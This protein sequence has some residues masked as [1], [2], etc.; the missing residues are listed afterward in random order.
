MSGE[1]ASQECASPS[2]SGRDSLVPSHVGLF[3]PSQ[4]GKLPPIHASVSSYSS[5]RSGSPR[6]QPPLLGKC[7]HHSPLPTIVIPQA[8]KACLAGKRQDFGTLFPVYHLNESQREGNGILR[9]TT[10]PLKNGILQS[11]RNFQLIPK[12]MLS[13]AQKSTR[14]ES[15]R[16]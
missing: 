16:K 12:W 7:F 15:Y 6:F 10:S 4:C 3:W 11:F 1:A 8:E 14:K 2:H 5:K 13:F 9:P